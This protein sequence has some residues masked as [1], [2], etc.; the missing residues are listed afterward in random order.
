M[1]KIIFIDIDGVLCLDSE[2]NAKNTRWGSIHRFNNKAVKVLNHIL[3]ITDADLVISSDWKNNNN[4][5]FKDLQ[6][7]FIEW[8]G[9]IKQPIDVTPNLWGK[10][11]T[12]LSQLEECRSKEIL[13]YVKLYNIEKWVAVDDLDLSNYLSE[14]HFVHT[15]RG[16]EGIK[17][18]GKSKEI[19]NKLIKN[20]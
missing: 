15:R 3:N 8:A 9:I 18:T 4:L 5:S 11:F 12:K 19:I 1:N 17:Q 16:N 6:E 7:I 2:I 10:E 20:D 14:D 13:E